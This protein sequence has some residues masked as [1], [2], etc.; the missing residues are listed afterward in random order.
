MNILPAYM[1]AYACCP[2]QPEEGVR[3]LELELLMIVNSV[4]VLGFAPRASGRATREWV[5]LTTEILFV[6]IVVLC[7]F[8]LVLRQ[9][10][11]T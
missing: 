10:L 7:L 4:W 6:V 2:Q 1:P 8:L 5:L 3:S 9:G 11:S